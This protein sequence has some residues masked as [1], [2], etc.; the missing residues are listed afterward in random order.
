MTMTCC[1]GETPMRAM[2]AWRDKSLSFMAASG[3]PRGAAPPP[4][5]ECA[6]H[7]RVRSIPI[8]TSLGFSG[9]RVG[10]GWFECMVARNPQYDGIFDSFH[11]GALSTD[12]GL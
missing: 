5:R 8:F 3:A 2:N 11:G 7:E 9:I 4:E 1:I 6:I 12:A 10:V